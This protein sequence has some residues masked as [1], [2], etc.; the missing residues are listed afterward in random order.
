MSTVSGT[1]LDTC[2]ISVNKIN[3]FHPHGAYLLEGEEE[4]KQ[5]V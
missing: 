1:L 3:I 2:E 4:N 5:H